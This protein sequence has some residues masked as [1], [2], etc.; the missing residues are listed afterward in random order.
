MPFSLYINFKIK[1]MQHINNEN[2]GMGQEWRI[3]NIQMLKQ[4]K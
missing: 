2:K 3:L 4:M 1:N